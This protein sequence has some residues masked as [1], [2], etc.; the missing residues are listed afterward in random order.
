MSAAYQAASTSNEEAY[1]ADSRNESFW[2]FDMRR[3]SAEELRDT[4]HVVSGAF[5]PKMYGPGIYPAI[6]KE[7]LATQSKPGHGWGNSSPE[8]QARR[9]VYIHVKRSLLTPILADFDL[10]DTDTTCPVRFVTTQPTQALGM[11][12]SEFMQQQ[13]KV[14]AERIAEEAGGPD[15]SDMEACVRRAI[16]VALVRDAQDDE[17][18]HGLAL[19]DELETTEGISPGRSLE[20]YCLFLLN[21]NEFA[22]LD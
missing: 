15:R 2:R 18:A 10:A 14:F 1:A 6:P 11:M 8:E 4:V 17:I 9:S 21:L 3:L 12:N 16:E 19:I 20:L 22:Y 5:N 13:S 7:V